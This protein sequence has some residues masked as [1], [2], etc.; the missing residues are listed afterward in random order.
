MADYK[1]KKNHLS[2]KLKN[3][4]IMPVEHRSYIVEQNLK[5]LTFLNWFLIFAGIIMDSLIV[6]NNLYQNHNQKVIIYFFSILTIISAISLIWCYFFKNKT[7]ISS[8]L[9]AIGHYITF[10]AI[11]CLCLVSFLHLFAIFSAFIYFICA[12]IVFSLVFYMEPFFFSIVLIS[13]ISAMI[14][15]L[16]SSFGIPAII[17]VIFFSAIMVL[18]VF[19]RWNSTI[20][21]LN[22]Q[23]E[24][25]RYTSNLEKEITLASFVQK[26]FFTHNVTEFDGWTLNFYSEPMAGISGDMFDIY[27]TD[28]K[29]DGLG[30]FDVSGH[31]L[32]SGLVTMLVKNIIYKEF[33]KQK[34]KPLQQ[35]LNYINDRIIREKGDIENF[36]T[37]TLARIN[38][39]NVEFINAGNPQPIIYVKEKNNAFFYENSNQNHYGVIGMADFPVNYTS[40]VIKMNSGDEILFYTDGI[41]ENTNKSGLSY[42][43]DL[44]LETFKINTFKTCKDQI[45]DLIA[46][47]K[48]FKG[49]FRSSDDITVLLLKKL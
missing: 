3:A 15:K 41:T 23:S 17:V 13:I 31:G 16:V 1:T 6:A 46:H 14:P 45:S 25:K 42:G 24:Q 27:N 36:L 20:K 28:N 12:V 33:Y 5:R 49:D 19:S 22:A 48:A 34:D 40:T 11:M 8:D 39:N 32:S 38:G 43:K 2:A 10:L 29:L 7:T 26:S 44:L 4:L 37:G 18:I 21:M 9:R 47:Y 30:L 35:V